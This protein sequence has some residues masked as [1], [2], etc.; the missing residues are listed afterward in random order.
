[1]GYVEFT[2]GGLSI[3]MEGGEVISAEPAKLCDG[4]FQD[5]SPRGGREI[6]TAE[7]EVIL[8]LCESCKAR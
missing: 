2:K 5:V 8:W 1:M 7:G 3:R 4:C 6:R